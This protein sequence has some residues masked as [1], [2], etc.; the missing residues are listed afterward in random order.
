MNLIG[1]LA[2][3]NL[4]IENKMQQTNLNYFLLQIYQAYTKTNQQLTLIFYE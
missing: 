1:Y 3:C 4:Q 2:I